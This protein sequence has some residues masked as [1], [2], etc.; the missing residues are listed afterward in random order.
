MIHKSHEPTRTK[1]TGNLIFETVSAV[2]GIWYSCE[3]FC[4]EGILVRPGP[5]S[6][7]TLRLNGAPTSSTFSLASQLNSRSIASA[8]SA[9]SGILQTSS[10]RRYKYRSHLRQVLIEKSAVR[11]RKG[12]IEAISCFVLHSQGPLPTNSATNF[13]LRAKSRKRNMHT[14]LSKT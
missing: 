4:S 5:R 7:R 14:Q 13:V 12:E 10:R 1:L 3:S 11:H 2:G 9:C 8:S 6:C